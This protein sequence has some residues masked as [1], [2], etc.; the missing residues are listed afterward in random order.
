MA[1]I[2]KKLPLHEQIK[3]RMEI[4]SLV[5]NAELRNITH[6]SSG[7]SDSSR[8]GSAQSTCVPIALLSPITYSEASNDQQDCEHVLNTCEQTVSN[9]INPKGNI[10]LFNVPTGI[11][12]ETVIPPASSEHGTVVVADVECNYYTKL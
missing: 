2:V 6:L 9:V 11:A 5:G 7:S 3:L 12:S 4:S 10:S 8:P 1:K